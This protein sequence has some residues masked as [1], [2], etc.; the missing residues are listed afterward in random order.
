MTTTTIVENRTVTVRDLTVEEQA[1]YDLKQVA[2]E[3]QRLPME[4]NELREKRN[5][6]L[7]ETDF[8]GMSDRTMSD[9]MTTYRQQLRDITEGLDTVEK[10]E[11]VVFPDKP[12]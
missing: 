12:L 5:N 9:A 1:E 3:N 7:A 11:A 2:W 10:V 8:Y 4:L 6:R